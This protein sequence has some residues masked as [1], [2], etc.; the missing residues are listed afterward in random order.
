MAAMMSRG[1]A[2]DGELAF[3]TAPASLHASLHANNKHLLHRS[4]F[5]VHPS[6]PPAGFAAAPAAAASH[7]C[8]S[9]S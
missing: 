8:R 2:Q 7:C 6:Y 5:A 9:W 4:I 1:A 3:C